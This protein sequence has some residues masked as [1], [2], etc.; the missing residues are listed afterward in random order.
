VS[1]KSILV[2]AAHPD[3]EALG[4]AG[5]LAKNAAE[6]NEVNICFLADGETSREGA[7]RRDVDKRR[8]KS[9]DAAKII[10][11]NDVCFFNY[12]DNK[13]DTISLL[14]LAYTVEKVVDKYSPDTIFTHS[15]KD[16]NVDHELTFRA[17]MTAAR[18][19]PTSKILDIY[20]FE[21]LSSTDWFKLDERF[22]P[23]VFV[24]IT[25]YFELKIEALSC[26]EKEMR[27][28]PHARSNE[29]VEYLAR[30]R[31]ASIGCEYAEAFELI[32]S[33]R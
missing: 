19:L 14:D 27:D 2:V 7:S 32:R 26:Y 16:L 5:T 22:S 15:Y 29:N 18:P 1:K 31:G 25:N 20:S 4:C 30:V 21:V 8:A 12:P 9:L 11:A 33:I 23:S 3:D 6:N 28:F 10:G 13:L 24:D 17:V